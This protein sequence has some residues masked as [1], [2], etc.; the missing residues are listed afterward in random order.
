MLPREITAL[1]Y[2]SNMWQDKVM[3]D[4]V[5]SLFIVFDGS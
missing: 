4:D 2:I 3:E 5:A 1:S